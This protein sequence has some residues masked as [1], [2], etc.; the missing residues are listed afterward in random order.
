MIVV[1]VIHSSDLRWI[2]VESLHL[3]ETDQRIS[4][5]KQKQAKSYG[6]KDLFNIN[7]VPQLYITMS[8]CQ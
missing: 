7:I 3:T 6:H 2:I 1:I 8:G 4:T 5:R